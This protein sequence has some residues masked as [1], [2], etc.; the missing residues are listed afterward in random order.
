MREEDRKRACE[1]FQEIERDL[2]YQVVEARKD[3]D[4]ETFLG[5]LD[6]LRI[7]LEIERELC[8]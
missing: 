6:N 1:N 4:L 5:G 3:R 2:A 7:L 8:K